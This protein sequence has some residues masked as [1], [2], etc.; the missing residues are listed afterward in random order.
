MEIN[1]QKY[2][3]IVIKIGSSLIVDNKNI[4]LKWLENLAQNIH[5]I[6]VKNNC[7]IIIV[8][9]GAVA[10]GRL[11]LN[12]KNQKLSIPEKQACAGV[13]QIQLMSLYQ[14]FFARH[15]TKVA[16]ILLT[17]TDC[18]SRKSY[19][20]IQNTINKLLEKNIIPIINENDSV[21]VDELKI[22]DNDRLSA[23]VSQMIK[24]D[25]MILLSDIDGL[26]D[27]NPKEY[28]SAQFISQV[29]EITKDIE[30][31]AKGTSSKVGTGGMITK[32]MAAKMAK[33]A[34]CATI[35]TSGIEIDALKK[36]ILGNKKFTLFTTKDLQKSSKHR[37][38]AKKNWL[39]GLVNSNREIIIN[40]DAVLALKKNASLL[41][42]G[43]IGVHGNFSQGDAVFI[44]DQDGNHI[45]N[46]VVSYSSSEAKKILQKNSNEIKKILGSKAKPE[47]VH[48]DNI[49]IMPS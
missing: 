35:I 12:Y 6:R 39:S 4:R 30:M 11:A 42:V 43:A 21:A 28:I 37:S 44:K 14:D 41:A 16:Q 34:N 24:A 40:Q 20:H 7:Q 15:K 31:M 8:T 46:G 45:A 29:D 18:N 33:S 32:I 5:E 22:G 48:V 27:K 26:F 3:K 2:Q 47:L 13:G 49:F 25:L 36:L 38:K 17:A 23:R 1:S 10:F 19:L 9:S